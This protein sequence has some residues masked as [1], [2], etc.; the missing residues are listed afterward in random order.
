[1]LALVPNYQAGPQPSWEWY[2][3][4]VRSRPV[5]KSVEPFPS[6]GAARRDYYIRFTSS[7]L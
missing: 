2:H 1:M 4:D 6:K 3:L 7:F 5:A